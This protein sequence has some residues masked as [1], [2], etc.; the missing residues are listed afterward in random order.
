MN[1]QIFILMVQPLSSVHHFPSVVGHKHIGT[2]WE[3]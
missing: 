2:L 1:F 3:Q